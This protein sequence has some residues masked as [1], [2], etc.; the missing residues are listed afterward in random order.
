MAKPITTA[1]K[2]VDRLMSN[3]GSKCTAALPPGACFSTYR[4]RDDKPS[5]I[6]E[7]LTYTTYAGI[8]FLIALNFGLYLARRPSQTLTEGVWSTFLTIQLTFGLAG[9]FP[10]FRKT[11]PWALRA[12]FGTAL[13]GL[14][15][16]AAAAL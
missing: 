13:L 2:G 7:E 1:T 9:Y 6:I 3:P 14:A 16:Q 5:P 12:T 10:N 4:S 15:F 8:S 11:P